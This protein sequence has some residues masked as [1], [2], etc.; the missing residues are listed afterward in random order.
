[1]GSTTYELTANY[2]SAR[3]FYGKAR[4]TRYEDGSMTLTSYDTAVAFF[5]NGELTKACGQPQSN[6]TAR[7]MREFA[8]QLGLPWMS[9][10]ELTALPTR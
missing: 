5:K 7:H 8:R 10:T 9:K 3:S 2:D 6:T 4:V 1:M